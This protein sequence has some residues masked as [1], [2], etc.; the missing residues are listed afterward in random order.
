MMNFFS[1]LKNSRGRLAGYALLWF[2]GVP[3]PLL[4]L[5]ALFRGC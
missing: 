2:L 3:L 1:S 5:I 4:L